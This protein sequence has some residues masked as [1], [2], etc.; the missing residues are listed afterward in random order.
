MIM[1]A[2]FKKYWRRLR[3]T[4]KDADRRLRSECIGI[5]SHYGVK[6]VDD[7]LRAAQQI[8]DWIECGALPPEIGMGE[9]AE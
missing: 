6:R 9:P 4:E 2:W 1:I 8:Y 5:A 7:L 3:F